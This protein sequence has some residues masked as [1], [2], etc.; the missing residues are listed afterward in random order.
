[1]LKLGNLRVR[2]AYVDIKGEVQEFNGVESVTVDNGTL[3]IHYR[4][5]DQ[6]YLTTLYPAGMWGEVTLDPEAN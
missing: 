6:W 5:V 3:A 1:M 2:T 4:G